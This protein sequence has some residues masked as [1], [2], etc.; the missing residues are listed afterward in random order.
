MKNFQLSDIGEERMQ[1]WMNSSLILSFHCAQKNNRDMKTYTSSFPIVFVSSKYWFLG[2]ER[3]IYCKSVKI[4]ELAGVEPASKQGNHTLST[5]LFQSSVFERR[6]DLDHQS[7]PY[8]LK[9]HPCIEACK[10]YFRFN[11]RR[12]I[13]GFGTTSSGRRLVLLPCKRIKLVIY[14][15]SIKQREHTYCCQLIFCSLS[16]RS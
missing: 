8:P 16:L 11:L 3:V 2:V 4:V 5:R 10:G 9:F 15:A 6:Q 1:T 13:S 7:S 12:L 14:C